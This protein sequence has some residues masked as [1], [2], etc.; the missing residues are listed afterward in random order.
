MLNVIF[1]YSTYAWPEGVT[2]R[3]GGVG[4]WRATKNAIEVAKPNMNPQPYLFIIERGSE[5]AVI[6]LFP[7]KRKIP[8]VSKIPQQARAKTSIW[9]LL[10][11]LL[12]HILVP[13]SVLDTARTWNTTETPCFRLH[14]DKLINCWNWRDVVINVGMESGPL[15]ACI[16][17]SRL[18]EILNTT[19]QLIII[20]PQRKSI[21]EPGGGG[22]GGMVWLL[23]YMYIK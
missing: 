2:G 10:N 19:D 6:F 3:G 8:I 12:S 1:W 15:V 5:Y 23:K 9:P 20:K 4:V 11:R 16:L 14:G 7:V 21:L 18:T 22:W 13:I 17:C